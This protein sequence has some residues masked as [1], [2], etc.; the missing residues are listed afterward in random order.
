MAQLS[1]E[2]FVLA[3]TPRQRRAAELIIKA[4]ERMESIGT[5]RNCQ[6]LLVCEGRNVSVDLFRAHMFTEIVAERETRVE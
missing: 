6:L 2:L 5:D 4:I 1:G 3:R